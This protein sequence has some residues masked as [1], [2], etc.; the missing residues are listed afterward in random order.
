[1]T[2]L[3]HPGNNALAVSLGNSF[4]AGGA[5]YY[6]DQWRAVAGRPA[7]L[8]LELAVWYAN[9]TTITVVSDGSW[10]A[11]TG[12]TTSNTPA[13]ESYDARLAQPGWTAVMFDD[14]GWDDA[15]V[16]AA[17]D[18]VLRAET[19]PPVKE[20]A[21][22]KPVKV[23]D[24]GTSLPVPSFTDSPTPDWIWNTP[25]SNGDAAQRHD[26]SAQDVHHAGGRHAGGFANQRR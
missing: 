22:I 26:L 21:T 2:R 9:G 25:N 1:M 23:T 4:Y 15:S 10:K 5:D 11:T 7:K 19:I 14:S 17:P 18:A 13:F 8:K 20:T 6:P 16:L 12:P 3:L 24:V